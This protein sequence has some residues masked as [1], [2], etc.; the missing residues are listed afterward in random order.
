VLED[1][2]IE[3]NALKLTLC[4]HSAHSNVATVR[5]LIFALGELMTVASEQT[6]RPR[7]S[8]ISLGNQFVGRE[9][10]EGTPT[11][12][13]LR[14]SSIAPCDFSSM[15]ENHEMLPIVARRRGAGC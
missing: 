2:A 6:L 9:R 12:V 13:P 5:E 1:R 11:A 14:L 15:Q 3:I 8:S 10:H 7:S 4:P